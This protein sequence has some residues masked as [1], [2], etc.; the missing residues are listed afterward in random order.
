MVFALGLCCNFRCQFGANDILRLWKM[1][2]A[3]TLHANIRLIPSHLMRPQER[4]RQR[5]SILMSWKTIAA[6][7]LNGNIRLMAPHLMSP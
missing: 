3:T 5:T 7:T 1:I 2:V 6:T 4:G